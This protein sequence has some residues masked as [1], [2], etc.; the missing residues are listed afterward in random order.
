MKTDKNTAAKTGD[1]I[2]VRSATTGAS[3]GDYIITD[4]RSSNR[5]TVEGGHDCRTATV[6]EVA[7]AKAEGRHATHYA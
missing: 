6:Q 7:Q 1:V 3:Y 4:Q 2:E 5:C